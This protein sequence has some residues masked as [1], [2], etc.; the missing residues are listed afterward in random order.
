MWEK[1]LIGGRAS[2]AFSGAFPPVG[3]DSDPDSYNLINCTTDYQPPTKSELQEVCELGQDGRYKFLY[4][5]TDGGILDGLPINKGIGF[6]KQLIAND[7]FSN[8]N[9]QQFSEAYKQQFLEFRT[10]WRETYGSA[11]E[12]TNRMYA[13]RC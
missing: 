12:A 8:R 13:W 1:V 10:Q 11:P 4:S 3:D 6:F 9:A 2:G 7:P 5:Y